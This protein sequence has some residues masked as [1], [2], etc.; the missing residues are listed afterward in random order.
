MIAARRCRRSGQRSVDVPT[1]TPR[2]ILLLEGP[3]DSRFWGA[4]GSPNQCEIVIAAAKRRSFLRFGI[5]SVGN[6]RH[7]RTG[8]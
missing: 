8:R 5:R 3:D 4:A 2:R 7:G 6:Q 1:G